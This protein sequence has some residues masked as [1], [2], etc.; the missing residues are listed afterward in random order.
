[1]DVITLFHYNSRGALIDPPASFHPSIMVGCGAM[2]TPAF[3]SRYNITHVI[4]CA[5]PE[6]SPSWFRSRHPDKYFCLEAVDSPTTNILNWYPK[7][8]E[9]LD[10][11]LSD[12]FSKRVFVHCQMGVNRSGFLSLAYVC[13]TFK[14]PL[15][16]VIVKTIRQRPCLYQN[17]RFLKDVSDLVNNG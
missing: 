1:M 4:N 17:P 14:Y 6:H 11:F 9:V 7:F 3:T 8:K 5:F 13:Q 2:L 16:D 15:K 10:Q 12:P